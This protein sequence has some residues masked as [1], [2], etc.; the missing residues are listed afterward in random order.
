MDTL[1]KDRLAFRQLLVEH[2]LVSLVGSEAETLSWLET[3]I[4]ELADS[5]ARRER[6]RELL[7][8]TREVLKREQARPREGDSPG[9]ERT[10]RPNPHA[11]RRFRRINILP[12]GFT[13]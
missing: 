10:E 2:G 3:Q 11:G 12:P 5:V 9:G 6:F 13:D 1:A 7:R 8:Q 4:I